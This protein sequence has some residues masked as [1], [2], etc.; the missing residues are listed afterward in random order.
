MMVTMVPAACTGSDK[1]VLAALCGSA[2]RFGP[3]AQVRGTMVLF[4]AF[5]QKN[6][7]R[8]IIIYRFFV[9][10]NRNIPA[11]GANVLIDDGVIVKNL[12]VGLAHNGF[13]PVYQCFSIK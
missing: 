3:G 7:V 13:P 8:S 11:A 12:S 9:P 1:Y 10:G 5:F 2:V 6:I 4:F